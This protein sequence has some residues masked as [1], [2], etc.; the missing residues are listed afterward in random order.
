MNHPF[1]SFLTTTRRLQTRWSRINGTWF[2]A[3]HSLS[4]PFLRNWSLVENVL[5]IW[6]R[7][8]S[9]V[10]SFHSF[11]ACATLQ[12]YKNAS[13]LKEKGLYSRGPNRD[14][15]RFFFVAFAT[16]QNLLQW[17]IPAE[18]KGWR[19]TPGLEHVTNE[20]LEEDETSFVDRFGIHFRTKTT[21]DDGIEP[22]E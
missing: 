7:R 20:T 4:F 16:L 15:L 13:N 18:K 5:L 6:K 14:L 3:F 8:D 12:I 21:R 22:Q 2:A 1:F 17:S 9:P 11:V 19:S 10:E